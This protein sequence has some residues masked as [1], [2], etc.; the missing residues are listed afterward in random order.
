MI[1]GVT[2][3]RPD[4]LGG[5]GDDA[6]LLLEATA[7]KALKFFQPESVITGMALGW[8]IAIAKA[9]RELGIPY[10]AAV[11][12]RGQESRWPPKSQEIYR[13][14]L[15]KAASIVYVCEDGYAAWKMQVRN[16]Y[17]VDNSDTLL[18]LWNGDVSG[19]TFNCL[20][21]ARVCD[22]PMYNAWGIFQRSIEYPERL[23]F[24]T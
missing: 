8:D 15:A 10:V 5:Y 19:G 17:I 16:K 13:T 12:F 1:L 23:T 18:S 3:H 2:G 21:Y 9:C 14:Y 24:N 4:K 22:K 6:S 11:P 7:V 20:K